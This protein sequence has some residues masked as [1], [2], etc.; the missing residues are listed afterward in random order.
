MP[1]RPLP[2]QKLIHGECDCGDIAFEATVSKTEHVPCDCKDCRDS[3]ACETIAFIQGNPKEFSK[4]GGP[5]KYFCGDCGTVLCHQI[6]SD[7]I[8]F[9]VPASV[10]ADSSS[11]E[12]CELGVQSTSDKKKAAAMER[13]EQ[14]E[15]FL[16]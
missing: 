4:K 1:G 16:E 9:S 8:N 13:P 6:A 5:V 11:T 15:C 14:I 10:I 3:T 2:V 12:V 7:L